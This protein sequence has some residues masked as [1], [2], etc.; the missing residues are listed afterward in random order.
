MAILNKF[1][2]SKPPAQLAVEPSAKDALNFAQQ[3]ADFELKR[4]DRMHIRF[5]GFITLTVATL[6]FIGWANLKTTAIDVATRLVDQ[7][8]KELVAQRLTDSRLTA[9]VDDEVKKK[10]DAS[11]NL[12]VQIQVQS[13]V[14]T[15]ID[16]RLGPLVAIAVERQRASIIAEAQ[17]RLFL[18]YRNQA[19]SELLHRALHNPLLR[20]Q[21]PPPPSFLLLSSDTPAVEHHTSE[22]MSIPTPIQH[23]CSSPIGSLV[24]LELVPVQLYSTMRFPNFP[25]HMMR[26]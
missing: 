10:A 5:M 11:I 24:S 19:P 7:Q 21:R 1:L 8:V 3:M 25:M 14:Q 2:P 22:L 9:L 16:E 15:A 13:G 6:A 20:P 12:Q 23:I 26:S 17:K 18:S 4:I